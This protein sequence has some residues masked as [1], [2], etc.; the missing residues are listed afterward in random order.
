[1]PCRSVCAECSLELMGAGPLARLSRPV[2]LSRHV[3]AVPAA[4]R[5]ARATASERVSRQHRQSRGRIDIRVGSD[6]QGR[7]VRPDD[8]LIRGVVGRQPVVMWLRERPIRQRFGSGRA[9]Y[10]FATLLAG[11]LRAVDLLAGA[12]RAAVFLAG[13][14]F[15]A[16][17]AGALA[18]TTAADLP[19]AATAE[20]SVG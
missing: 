19:A 4:G 14:F 6:P 20:S 2:A 17:R 15:V 12:L 1:M 18:A 13:A 5:A 3:G 8:L 7:I 16:L 9:C 10:R 11:A